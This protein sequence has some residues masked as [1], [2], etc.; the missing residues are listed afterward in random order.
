MSKY[1]YT[2]VVAKPESKLANLAYVVGTLV[3]CAVIGA[4]MAWRG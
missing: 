3:V 4:M 2:P 1:S